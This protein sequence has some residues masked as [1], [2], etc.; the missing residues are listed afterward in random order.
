MRTRGPGFH[1]MFKK[2]SLVIV[3]LMSEVLV[4]LCHFAEASE[5]PCTAAPAFVCQ[6]LTV[7]NISCKLLRDG[8]LVDAIGVTRPAAFGSQDEN[9][10]FSNSDLKLSDGRIRTVRVEIASEGIQTPTGSNGQLSTHF[11]VALSDITDMTDTIEATLLAG[12]SIVVSA[13]QPVSLELDGKLASSDSILQVTCSSL[14]FDQEVGVS[15]E[16][17]NPKMYPKP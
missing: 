15:D 14:K 8:S 7:E 12:K 13:D 3:M 10:A 11:E 6:H 1:T 9:N 4:G 5:F 17:G 16:N 2:Q